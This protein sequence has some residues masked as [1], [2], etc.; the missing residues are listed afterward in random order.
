MCCIYHT[1]DTVEILRLLPLSYLWHIVSVIYNTTHTFSAILSNYPIIH[2]MIWHALYCFTWLQY[3]PFRCKNNSFCNSSFVIDCFTSI[4]FTI[5]DMSF[6]LVFYI[7]GNY[8]TIS[9]KKYIYDNILEILNIPKKSTR[10]N[11]KTTDGHQVSLETNFSPLS[12]Q[13]DEVSE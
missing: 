9:V 5:T 4:P 6:N 11:K 10:R 13:L 2:L 8:R 12:F 1:H 7:E 3:N